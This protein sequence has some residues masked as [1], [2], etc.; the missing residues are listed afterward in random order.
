LEGYRRA[1]EEHNVPYDQALMR[2]GNFD[3]ES[4]YA[5]IRELL[6]ID[7]VPTA[8]FIGSDMVAMGALRALQEEGVSVPH[9]LAIVGF[10]DITAARFITPALTTVHVPTFGLGWSAAELL[11]RIIEGE[12]PNEIHVLLDTDLVVRESCGG[13]KNRG[14]GAWS[15][16]AR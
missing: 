9:D 13:S 6:A 7:E 3:E 15:A 14:R 11:I 16:G 10:D 8:V 12:Q 2:Q 1:L 4:G 5:A